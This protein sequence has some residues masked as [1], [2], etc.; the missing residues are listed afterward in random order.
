MFEIT[1]IGNEE[2][3]VEFISARLTENANQAGIQLTINQKIA[4]EDLLN[5][6]L[7]VR[8]NNTIKVQADRELIDFY[9]E[10]NSLILKEHSYGKMKKIIV[11]MD[12]SDCSRQAMEYAIQV[13]R[14][15]HAVLKLIFV[16]PTPIAALDE[17]TIL[18]HAVVIGLQKQLFDLQKELNA[19]LDSDDWHSP[20]VEAEFRTGPV[21]HQI[22]EFISENDNSFVVMGSIGESDILDKMFGSVS[23]TIVKQSKSPVLIIPPD[24]QYKKLEHLA[25][26]SNDIQ[27]DKAE[28]TQLLALI[29]PIKPHLHLL[30]IENDNWSYDAEE[31]IKVAKENYYEDKVSFDLIRGRDKRDTLKGYC[32]EN[33][34]DL[35]VLAEKNKGFFERLFHK[36]FA[37]EIRQHLD[38][39]L[40]VVHDRTE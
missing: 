32:S 25:Y 22:L 1:L 19:R 33:N 16:Y 34:I 2:A 26:C 13:A 11:P 29:K 21:E 28:I 12:F 3:S 15:Y 30:H 18:N 38:L 20:L 23:A 35:L 8:I 14:D 17:K 36:S 39:P 7:S 10:V 4:K 40:L 6:G 5:Q 24:T 37:K 31:L 27:L 9:R